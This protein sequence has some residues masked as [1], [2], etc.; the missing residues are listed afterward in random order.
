MANLRTLLIVA[1]LTI[2]FAC[3][4]AMAADDLSAASRRVRRRVGRLVRPESVRVALAQAGLTSIPVPAWILS[5][6]GLAVAAAAIAWAWFGLPVLGLI[7]FLV[8]Y[9][10]IGTALE[11]RRRGFEARHQEALLEAVR[12]GIAVMSRAGNAT[13]MLEALADG[14]PFEVRPLFKEIV[15]VGG[16][17]PAGETFVRELER[18]RDRVADPLF[19]DVVLALTLHWRQGGKLV[20]ALEAVVNDWSETLRLQREAKALRSGV[21]AS[22]VLLALLPFVF[23]VT[24]QLLA[25]TL[26]A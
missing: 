8:V 9:H 14:G 3:L 25:P 18:I 10:L 17:G 7:A 12:H 15:L 24:L 11:F 21:E 13:S 23:L 4:A 1:G 2:A 22:V 20:P 5:R 26:L 19:D 16:S 6:T